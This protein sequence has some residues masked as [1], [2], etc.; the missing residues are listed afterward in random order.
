MQ[1]FYFILNANVVLCNI[2][3]EIYINLNK[4]NDKNL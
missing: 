2:K 3:Y 4:D 1:C